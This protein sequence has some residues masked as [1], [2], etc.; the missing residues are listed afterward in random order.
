MTP[1]ILIIDDRINLPRFIAIELHAEGYQVSING[2]ADRSTLQS[3]NPDL[4]I[5][6]WELRHSSGL[7]VYQHLRSV[8]PSIP[9]VV[10]TAQGEDSCRQALTL[11]VKICLTKPFS[12][13][14][15]LRA[16]ACQLTCK[17]Q[18][19]GCSSPR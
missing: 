6:N 14:D 1:H 8:Y 3:I 9:I 11:G 18:K 2:D 19:I 13:D 10:L 15:L 17:Q 16:I 5:L 12:M 7:D 4:I